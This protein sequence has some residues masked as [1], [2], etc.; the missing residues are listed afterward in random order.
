M[1][2]GPPGA[3]K[4]TVAA[5]V[6]DRFERSVLVAGDT[7]F[8]FVR[9]GYIDPWLPESHGQNA[10]VTEAS[11]AATARY[12]AGGFDTVFDGV[13]G[14]W[15]LPTFAAMAGVDRLDYAVLLPPVE[16]CIHRVATRHG[17]GFS[18]EPATRKMYRE[19]AGAD[20]EPRHLLTDPSATP[21]AT[22]DAVMAAV[23]AGTLTYVSPG[24][25]PGG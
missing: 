10:V 23:E 8:G 17:H 2:T 4:S 16:V 6:A 5:L 7:F 20:V 24:R 3:G 14:A 11:A 22:A 12:V 13:V 25:R 19:F 21:T 1:I 15:F 18:D 9:K